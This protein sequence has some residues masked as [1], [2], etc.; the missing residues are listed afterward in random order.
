[1]PRARYRAATASITERLGSPS[2]TNLNQSPHVPSL[3]TGY[4]V[5]ESTLDQETFEVHLP[6]TPVPSRFLLSQSRCCTVRRRDH[7]L[8]SKPSLPVPTFPPDP[9]QF[10]SDIS[11][12]SIR[13][14]TIGPDFPSGG[15]VHRSPTTF[16]PAAEPSPMGIRHL[17][18]LLN[19]ALAHSR[20]WNVDLPSR[21]RH[22]GDFCF[23]LFPTSRK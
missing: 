21:V 8:R 3:V 7:A 20:Q 17:S 10:E 13:P 4:T 5:C 22:A 9:G 16:F 15:S 23:T 1:M 2:S 19:R 18:G 11:S 12:G 14:A 6:S